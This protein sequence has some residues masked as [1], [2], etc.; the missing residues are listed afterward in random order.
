[1]EA[2][3]QR[4]APAALPPGQLQATTALPPGETAPGNHCVSLNNPQRRIN[5]V[6]ACI[7][8]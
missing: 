4:H 3:G 6:T 2:S 8:V 1:M 5:A 7:L